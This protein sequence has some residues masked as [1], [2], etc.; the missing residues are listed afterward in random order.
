[1]KAIIIPVIVVA[2]VGL[3]L[4]LRRQGRGSRNESRFQFDL[5]ARTGDVGL[6][7]T[8][9][10]RERIRGR[11]FRIGTLL[12]LAVVA[13]AIVIPVLRSGKQQA[14]QIG[15]VGSVT[16]PL[17]A[18]VVAAGTSV[19][20]TAHLV[21]EGDLRIAEAKLRSGQLEVVVVDGE[22]LV[23]DKSISPTDSSTTAQLVLAVSKTLGV[24][25]AYE[26]ANLSA[27]QASQLAGAKPL[28]VTS[29]QAGPTK[30]ATHTTSVVGL[31][32]VFLMLTQYNT[33]ILIGVME[34][35]SSRVVEVLLAAVRPIQ[36]LA[37]KVLGIGL[38]AFAQ[39]GLIVAF[40]LILAKA[41]GSDLLHGT[42][43]VVL[44]S[45][46]VWL[47]L[48]Y[49]FYCWVYAAAGSMAERQDQVQSLALPLSLPIIAGYIISLTVAETGNPST[50][51]EVLAYFPP[52]A[53][54]AMPVLVGLARI[55]AK[56]TIRPA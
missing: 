3:R 21:P 14:Q 37:G 7:A 33:W 54:F 18:A 6:V 27:A 45:T 53:P 13:A 40:A 26:A 47:V 16:V 12:I 17:R 56:A 25:K 31:I 23:V 32:L 51:F 34:E 48:G 15:V 38:V 1:M 49:A 41:V 11:I 42:A 22:K 52:T 46:L 30:G 43:P 35:K 9:E 5:G 39:A 50:F 10:V 2:V 4:W 19:G 36:L 24:V 28:P 20:T 29:L 55:R 44:A 8:R